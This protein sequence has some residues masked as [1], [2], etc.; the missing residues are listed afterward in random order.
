MVDIRQIPG[1]M[2]VTRVPKAS[3]RP[4]E[5]LPAPLRIDD[6]QGIFHA[7][8]DQEG[9]DAVGCDHIPPSEPDRHPWPHRPHAIPVIWSGPSSSATAGTPR[10]GADVTPERARGQD[11]GHANGR[12][13]AYG[14][15]GRSGPLDQGLIRR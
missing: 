4:R 12:P 10:A 11:T 9:P 15:G 8:L 14:V 6:I 1:E 2:S 7:R 13:P 5:P 3:L